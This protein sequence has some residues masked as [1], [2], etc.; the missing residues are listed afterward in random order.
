MRQFTIASCALYFLTGLTAIS[1][2]SVMPQLLTYYHVSFTVGGQLIFVGA[3]GCLAGVLVSSWLNNH[4]PP[5]PLLI[6][7]TLLIAAAQFSILLLPPLPVFMTLY[8]LNSAGSSMISI[9][10]ATLFIEVFSGRQAVA[11][12]YLEV[13]FGLGALTM[14]VLASLF[15][16]L[17][18][19]RYLFIITVLFALILAGIWTHIQISN[20]AQDPGTSGPQDASGAPDT[21][22][23]SSGRKWAIL[24][25]FAFIVF[26]YGGLEGS[27]N[28]FMS[29]IF[30]DY[31]G[32]V[33]YTASISVGIFWCAMVIGRAL[34]GVIIRK[35]TYNR[36]LLMNICGA[37]ISLVLF[38]LMKNLIF[39]FIFVATLGLMLSG[40][41]SITLVYANYSIPN[42]V[43]LVTPI[44]SGLSGLGAAVFPAVTGF[45]IDHSGMMTTLWY[46]VGMAISYL[47]M[48]LVID[49]I[50]RRRTFKVFFP[51][52]LLR[53]AFASRRM[54]MK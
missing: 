27:L 33:A 47:T 24:G 11:M 36:Y 29:S 37:I 40:I 38:I 32:A 14:P 34:T 50:R 52:H 4:F 16:A 6:F 3:M 23:L 35:V 12:S 9:V 5:R 41:Y 54:R 8:F 22:P 48:L 45:S 53:P 19:W 26:V 43:H 28:N 46:L 1:I 42:S 30:I 51:H 31:L 39:G 18:I 44:I 10:V 21:R 20:N 49:Q 25:L 15:I 2:G 13:S 7:S 17:D